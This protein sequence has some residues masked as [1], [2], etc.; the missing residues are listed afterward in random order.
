MI[1]APEYIESIIPY[2]PGKPVKEV[3]REYG[4]TEA[5]KIASNENPLGP[6]PLAVKA[7]KAEVHELNRY[8][9]GGG[10]YLRQKLAQIHGIPPEKIILGNGSTE[11]IEIIAKTFLFHHEN[12]IVSRQAF[13]MY[14]LA[15]QSVN[16]NCIE[17]PL[18]EKLT[19]DLEAMGK[20]INRDTKIVYIANPN[21]PT[22]TYVTKDAFERFMISI[23]P[24][25]IVVADEA[26]REYIDDPDFPDSAAYLDKFDNLVI[27]RTF[28]KIYGLAG[29]RI[30]YGLTSDVIIEKLN[31]VRSPFNTNSLC[32]VAAIAAC[33]D[34]EHVER[35]KKTNAEE[36]E[37]LY[38][39]LDRLGIAY[40]P[41]ATNFILVDAGRDCIEV[42]TDMLKLGVIARP[43]KGYNF[44][45]SLRVSIGTRPENEAFLKVIAKVVK[46]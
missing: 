38:R 46:K 26:Y 35:S 19:H 16:G 37:Y 7:I 31:R 15:I 20:A 34:H 32:Q 4:I 36:K 21:N 10:Y 22:G 2:V 3:E 28:S 40:T 12:A 18:D 41:S 14:K 43:M 30:G 9:D 11:I 27:L 17:V 25:V 42:F 5:V 8:P 6:S 23:P 44:P 33:D 39:E 29:I 13:I 45:T 24:E 1:R